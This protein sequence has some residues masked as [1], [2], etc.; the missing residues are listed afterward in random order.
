[1]AA[2]LAVRGVVPRSAV[3][4]AL[5]TGPD[6][7]ASYLAAL[8]LGA[9]PALASTPTQRVRDADVYRDLLAGI[10]R[11]AR[12]RAVVCDLPTAA[13]L[14]PGGGESFD[15]AT[16]VT[17]LT[18]APRPRGVGDTRVASLDP[19]EVATIQYSSGS[20]GR[21]KGVRLTHRAML[22]NVRAVRAALALGPDDVSVNWIPLYHDMGL[23]DAL[24]VPLLCGCETVLLPTGDFVREPRLWL[25]AIT[26][27]RGTISWA[28]NFAYA[29]CVQRIPE[30]EIAGLDLSSWRL[31]LNAAE[32]IV[33]ETIAAFCERFAAAGFRDGAMTP[34]WGLAENVTIATVHPP[35]EPPRIE[36]IDRAAAAAGRAVAVSDDARGFGCVAVGRPLPGCKLEIRDGVHPLGE[37]AIG[38]VWLSSDS[39]FAGYDDA[40]AARPHDGTPVWLPT[41]DRGYVA[42][43]DLFFVARAR[44][45]IVIAGEK[46]A[47]HDVEAA[48]NAVPG[49]RPGCAAAFGVRDEARGTEALAAVVETRVEDAAERARLARAIRSQVTRVTGLALRHL[50]LVP[51]GGVKKTT[52]GKLARAATRAAYAEEARA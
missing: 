36:R 44:D 7:V 15:G 32:P 51:P 29:L 23:I 48:I 52:S 24:L 3:V 49:V 40:A 2:A 45:V 39:A 10:V 37:R 26:H 50:T 46:H 4:I 31:A 6:L 19:D 14:V 27:H 11:D 13:L 21:P 8:L 41:G 28:P 1:V 16:L 35:G 9:V 34:A 30:H 12:A 18:T 17:Q 43:G 20:T 22:N 33:P 25:E 47:P 38:D 5:P 42:D